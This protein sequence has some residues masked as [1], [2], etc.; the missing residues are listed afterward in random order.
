MMNPCHQP[1]SEVPA[2]CAA[3]LPRYPLAYDRQSLALAA[4]APARRA[5]MYQQGGYQ[6]P[7]GYPPQQPTAYGSRAAP[8]AGHAPAPYHGGGAAAPADRQDDRFAGK[9]A[10]DPLLAVSR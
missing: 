9:A 3:L 1:I 7:G 8:F 4:I 2:R 5:L 6:A 10:K